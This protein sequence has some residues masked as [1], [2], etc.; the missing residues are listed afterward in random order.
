MGMPVFFASEDWSMKNAQF[1][2]SEDKGQSLGFHQSAVLGN[3][4]DW[5]FPLEFF[6]AGWELWH[7]GG[8]RKRNRH[9][10]RVSLDFFPNL[11]RV[12]AGFGTIAVQ[13]KQDGHDWR[14]PLEFSQAGRWVIADLGT[15]SV[16]TKP[17]G[18]DWRFLPEFS[19]VR[20][21]VSLL[22]ATSRSNKATW[23]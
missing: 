3:G 13:E 2:R 22:L 1:S 17:N 20:G 4:H 10:W 6:P 18:H 11:S 8:S 21:G 9:D 16:H 15:I 7:K 19:P 23:P 5:R 12:V 14:L